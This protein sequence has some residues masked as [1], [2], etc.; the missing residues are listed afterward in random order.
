[1]QSSKTC[2][3][4]SIKNKINQVRDGRVV[5]LCSCSCE[6][7]K[8]GAVL[9]GDSSYNYGFH[10]HCPM[11]GRVVAQFVDPKVNQ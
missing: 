8:K 10:V 5:W 1:M 6:V 2:L 4:A 7:P 11:C 3:K 9:S